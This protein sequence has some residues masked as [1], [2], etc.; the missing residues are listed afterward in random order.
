ME[1]KDFNE[2]HSIGP[3]YCSHFLPCQLCKLRMM[4]LFVLQFICCKTVDLAQTNTWCTAPPISPKVLSWE[5]FLKVRNEKWVERN[6]NI[7][8][9]SFFMTYLTCDQKWHPSLTE[10]SKK[11]ITV[12]WTENNSTFKQMLP[13]M[14]FKCIKWDICL[15]TLLYRCCWNPPNLWITQTAVSLSN[16]RC[17]FVDRLCIGGPSEPLKLYSKNKLCL[18]QMM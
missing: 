11:Q 16:Q 5:L 13:T 12:F 9:V 18:A 4:F 2:E 3:L 14:H 1:D 17:A 6:K 10:S 8:T 7:W 15:R